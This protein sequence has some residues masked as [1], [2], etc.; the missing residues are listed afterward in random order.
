M[1]KSQDRDQSITGKRRVLVVDDEMINR[2]MLGLILGD[3]YDV[4]YAEN[5]E[6]A[7]Q[8]CSE[9]KGFLSLVLLDLMMPVLSGMEVLRRMK[10]DPELRVIPIIVLTA[11]QDA[12]T[13]SLSEGAID[14]IPKPYPTRDV[15]L[16]RVR[17]IIELTED[18]EIIR[19]TERDP[20][21]GL[22]N[23]EFFYSYTKQIDQRY[24][25]TQMDA[26]VVD[27]N[28]FRMINERFGTTYGDRILCSIANGVR[29]WA[30]ENGGI[31]CRRE[32]DTFLLYC[33]HRDDYDSVLENASTILEGEETASGSRVW[34]RM[35]VYPNADKT[36]DIER[37]FDRAQIAADMVQGSFAKAIG[38]YDED[39]HKKEL[40]D[41][42]LIEGFRQAIQERQFV[43]YYQPKNYSPFFLV[44]TF[45]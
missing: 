31:A 40:Y 18:R 12:E 24:P 42:Q 6:K 1:Q 10:D 17:R 19:K 13:Q 2:E 39:L 14:F 35:G 38:I 44:C 21:T 26:V 11:D 29:T 30:Q 37:R 25:D 27:V 8:I 34:L 5:G 15:I 28:H 16:A 20:L 23:R 32:A 7:L 36:L 9:Q 4:L 45:V 22:Y 33:P 3:D 41:E 43:V